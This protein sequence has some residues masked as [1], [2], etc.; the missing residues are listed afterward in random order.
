MAKWSD[1]QKAAALM[2]AEATSIS[3]A[4]KRTG[5]PSG[6]IKRWRSEERSAAGEPNQTN[7]TEPNRVSKNEQAALA[8]ATAKAVERAAEEIADRLGAIVD[9]LYR[10]AEN[11][12]GKVDVAISGGKDGESHDRDGAAWV[13]ALVGVMAQALDKAQLLTGK[14]TSRQAVEGQVTQRY[15]YD[16]TA[17]V[18]QYADVYRRLA[19]RVGRGAICGADAG[20][21]ARE[22]MD[23]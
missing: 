18:E 22:S 7:R 5:I 2:I 9:K 16:L 13:R 4:A 12:V 11:A 17:R 15:E 23:S 19:D 6:T 14:P 20:D 3:E 8:D 10:L 1:E 21:G